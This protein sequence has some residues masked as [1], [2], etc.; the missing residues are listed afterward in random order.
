M[1][2]RFQPI[3][4]SALVD[5][6][7]DELA[8][9]SRIFGIPRE[10]FW[11]PAEAPGLAREVYGV[12]LDTPFGVAAGPHSQM[13]QNIVV[14]WLCGARFI[15]LKTVQTLDELEISKPCID[16][17]DEG[18]NVEW[19]Q[20][21]KVAESFDEY[22]RAWILVHA[23]H[24]AL[25]YPGRP[26]VVFN[27]S[28]GYDLAGIQQPN[29]R[30]FLEHMREPGELFDAHLEAVARR[31]PAVRSLAV[32]RRMSDSVTLSTMHG[33][34]PDEI[35]RI[36]THLMEHW[37]LHTSVKLNPTLL[38]PE[39][40]RALLNQD[41]G[42][43]Q[44]TVPDAAFGHDLKWTD[45]Q[46]LLEGLRSTA[47]RR[48]VTFGVKLSNTL[49]VENHRPVFPAREKMM[50]L[51][52]RPLHALTVNLA[53]LVARRF[54]G[55]LLM[56]FAGGADAFNAAHLLR[57]GMSTVT[58]CSDLLKSGGYLRLRQYV[59]NAASA[60]AVVGAR[61]LDELVVESARRDAWPADAHGRALATPAVRAPQP[62][63]AS[64]LANLARYAE[65]VR[66]DRDYQR[67][68]FHRDKSKTRREL[69]PFDCIDAPCMDECNIRQQ[70]PRYFELV[71]EG[72]MPEAVAVTRADNALAAVLGRA[73]DH[74][75]E[76]TC[77]RT[78]YDE[79]LAIR[80][81]KRFIMDHEGELPAA[82]P[83]ATQAARV[84]VVGAGPCGLSAA[85]FLARA[86]YP[87]TVLEAH[88]KSG[89]QVSGT[90]PS[91]RLPLVP[92]ERDMHFLT[93]LGV[94]VEHG[95][96]VG[97]DF[98]VA[99]LRRQG[100]RY[101]VVAAGAQ[102]GVRLGLPGDDAEGVLDGL[103][104]L[105][106]V[107][108]G[109]PPALG[110]NVVVV[111]GGD[112]AMDCART[113]RR[114]GR[115][116]VVVAYRR[117][118]EEMPAQREE[119]VDLL[120]EGCELMELVAPVGL[121]VADGRL[122]AVRL[123]RMTLGPAD[124]SG[125]RRPV[126]SG[127]TVELRAD[128]LLS[129]IGQRTDLGLFGDEPPRLDGSGYVAVDPATRETSI[130]GVFAGGDVIGESPLSIVKAMGDGKHIA[131]EI[132]RRE[133]GFVEGALAPR[134]VPFV[135]LLR[136]RGE[137]VRRVPT[138]H[139][140]PAGRLDFTEVLLG[141]SPE[142]ARTEAERCLDCD[143]MCSLC[144]S[145]CPNL[146]F[147]TYE[148]RPLRAG[149][150]RLVRHGASYELAGGTPFEVAQGYQV[151]VLADFCNECG[152]CT[153][154]CPTAGEP[155]R[156]KPRLY[157]HR[158]EFDAQPD[159]AFQL[160]RADGALAIR[161]RFAGET[162]E[163]APDSR[164]SATLR[165]S[166]PHLDARLESSS[167]RLLEARARGET[168]PAELSLTP[169]LVLHALLDGIGRSL[170]FLPTAAS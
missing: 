75:C 129:A 31:F 23:L 77:V 154:F 16:M 49:E 27:I 80:E 57:A 65:L 13:A 100:Y 42:F 44:V 130:A 111:G 110:A 7:F 162:H 87:T 3:P 104:F 134:T 170:P 148:A 125:R 74:R 39:R 78:H 92:I 108:D 99:D 157:V 47:A 58:T 34:P 73:C 91:Y 113:A 11:R 30:W 41:L 66:T 67:D 5:W 25:G 164:A 62:L 156:Q 72:N 38:G 85:Y 21:L 26:G 40:V 112:V 139:R 84:A 140:E 69:G 60:L 61:S 135:D 17:Q 155:Y 97:V 43:R 123:E 8:H 127:E 12:R 51:S 35:G 136:R 168:A 15:E 126:P 160:W 76:N 70:V 141:Y 98:S 132:R 115:G 14:A 63:V 19:S 158:G 71:R 83:A 79:P 37:G 28:V 54:G 68:G 165:Y 95:R 94:H 6:I 2:D 143:V 147:F 116:R 120:A 22:L 64:A 153:T 151:A 88:P 167:A 163:L 86:G 20:E 144:V 145:V 46:P 102:R 55:E 121:A 107:R 138:P 146:A 9:K 59:H 52:G 96:R 29:V 128:N 101:V 117:S 152:N 106:A 82:P 122:T 149:G 118:R 18:Y 119:V 105:R 133:E 10:L 89:G 33:C 56:S 36:S 114:L 137:R 166:T 124:A 159:N 169:A 161:G 93:S 103:T 1:S 150:T 53:D 81:T 109:A 45:A 48:G 142:E 131:H 4:M 90:I 50:Y 32:P 24:A